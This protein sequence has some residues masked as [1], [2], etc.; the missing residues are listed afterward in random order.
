V[1][2]WRLSH[3]QGQMHFALAHG[4]HDG[5]AFER[6][7]RGTHYVSCYPWP[8]L[9]GGLFFRGWVQQ[10]AIRLIALP[11]GEKL[12]RMLSRT[13]TRQQQKNT[14]ARKK[15][16]GEMNDV[17]S[18]LRLLRTQRGLGL[19]QLLQKPLTERQLADALGEPRKV[20]RY[21]Q[22]FCAAGLLV[23]MGKGERVRY[24]LNPYPD[25]RF[26]YAN[27]LALVRALI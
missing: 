26:E 20:R 9:P 24:W 14:F 4:F 3:L 25:G 23:C 10:E 18:M 19:M 1:G 13:Y 15:N 8:N 21:L 2:I 22:V 16:Q 27:V 17:M 11:Q 7:V 5:W 12:A 6:I